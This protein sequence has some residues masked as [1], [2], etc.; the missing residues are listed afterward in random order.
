MKIFY[1]N[2]KL[3]TGIDG[4]DRLLYGGIQIQNIVIEP[5][6]NATCDVFKPL[7]IL[8]SGEVGTNKILLGMQI[9]HGL[10]KSLRS[11]SAATGSIKPINISD[12]IFYTCNDSVR[13]VQDMLLDMLISESIEHIKKQHLIDPKAWSKN[14]FSK[15]IFGIDQHLC[16]LPL[17][18]IRMDQCIAN[19]QIV[20]NNRTNALHS[21]N[22]D[23]HNGV[24]EEQ[25]DQTLVKRKYD[26]I[27]EYAREI[28]MIDNQFIKDEFFNINI[29]DSLSNIKILPGN[30][31]PCLL[32]D[33]S[34]D[35]SNFDV[36][37][38]LI[39][40]R[41][42]EDIQVGPD[43]K[44]DLIIE[45]RN[46]QHAV[47]DYFI[48]QL[49]IKK[50]VLQKTALGWHQYKVQDYG[51]E[52]YPSEHLIMQRRR[53]MPK[54][55]LRT[56]N[57]ILSETYTQYLD[58]RMRNGSMCGLSDIERLRTFDNSRE[59][60]RKDNLNEP[61]SSIKRIDCAGNIL[62][63]IIVGSR[64]KNDGC[65]VTALIGEAN[66]YKRFLT[67]G[68]TFSGA[69]RKE[70]TLK[71]LF[72]KDDAAMLRRVV[73]PA[74]MYLGKNLLTEKCL[75]NCLSCYEYVHFKEIRP[76]CIS[77]D[78]FFYYLI[79]QICLSNECADKEG[80]NH[81]IKR[82][83][84]DDLVRIDF[85][86]PMLKSDP[87]FLTTLI[88]I[89]RDYNIDLII[90][91]D[92]EAYLAKEL[93]VQADN[94]ICTERNEK[95]IKL[96]IEHYA[97]YN[98]PSHIYGCTITQIEELFCCDTDKKSGTEFILNEKH[99]KGFPVSSMREYWASADIE[100][101]IKYFKDKQ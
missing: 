44:P 1:D 58:R 50:C 71:I 5:G 39:I 21:I 32:I 77:S 23:R 12:S 22:Y 72:D 93:R 6:N 40:I 27:E 68:T 16:D 76:G 11:L 26:T 64:N 81:R 13:N 4:L 54:G 47:T 70:H 33:G 17:D 25:A 99:I 48:R 57:D 43:Y 53:H 28:A 20:Y 92:R 35:S 82:I 37:S 38:P 61:I 9:L 18:V 60:I 24:M 101:I 42:G 85:R 73:C 86:F 49:C 3:S 80:E 2:K 59:S 79:R 74:M 84:M 65:Q 88:S 34:K 63:E 62:K 29:I 41:F 15:A 83:V 89:C 56:H 94:V 31:I 66:T 52:V 30:Q 75:K 7:N 87:L 97:G 19:E 69:C 51:I 36:L 100:K 91:C 90:L 45:L 55:L 14:D 95:E 67:L 98:D 10:T 78:E 46:K 8:I 96:Y